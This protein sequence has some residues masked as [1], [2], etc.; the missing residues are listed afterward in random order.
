MKDPARAQRLWL[1][2]ATLWLVRV[3]GAEDAAEQ[4]AL[5]ELAALQDVPQRP[6]VRRWRLVSVFARGW[7]EIVVAL[8]NHG[9]LPLGRMVP[10]PWPTSLDLP[11]PAGPQTRRLRA[12]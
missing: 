3:G 8:I 4:A 10:L 1:A 2:V 5:P 9:R 6:R 11:P 12:A 7:V